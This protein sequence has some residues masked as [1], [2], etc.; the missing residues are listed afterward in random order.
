[1]PVAVQGIEQKAV[2]NLAPT[3]C[4]PLPGEGAGRHRGRLGAAA[5]I[6]HGR[7]RAGSGQGET[8]PA[9]S[10]TLA[11]FPEAEIQRRRSVVL[12]GGPAPVKLGEERLLTYKLFCKH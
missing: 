7:Q 9:T 6:H 12:R 2:R 3:A 4:A 1:M 8:A 11:C 10:K 5:R